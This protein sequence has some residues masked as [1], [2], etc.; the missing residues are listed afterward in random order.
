MPDFK[1]IE[2]KLQGTGGV[3]DSN[4]FDFL[5]ENYSEGGKELFERIINEKGGG[6]S[7]YSDD[8][9]NGI[10]YKQSEDSTQSRA[11][12]NPV[13]DDSRQ[14]RDELVLDF[15]SAQALTPSLRFES[16]V[17]GSGLTAAKDFLDTTALSAKSGGWIFGPSP[18]DITKGDLE[19]AL[20]QTPEPETDPT[21]GQEAD[22]SDIKPSEVLQCLLLKNIKPLS[23]YYKSAMHNRIYERKSNKLI[24][25]PYQGKIITL[26]SDPSPTFIN[27]LTLQKNINSNFTNVSKSDI[28]SSGTKKIYG[29]SLP[30]N[31]TTKMRLSFV[32][33]IE[34]DNSK[35]LVELPVLASQIS[36]E[37]TYQGDGSDNS[38]YFKERLDGTYSI[39]DSKEVLNKLDWGIDIKYEGTNPSTYRNDVTVSLTIKSNQIK[40]FTEAWKYYKGG[41]G[42]DNEYLSKEFNLFDLVLFPY[43]ES[44]SDG[45]GK[46]FKSQFSPNYNRVRLYVATIATGL[47]KEEIKQFYEK[48][49]TVLDLTPVDHEFTRESDGKVYSLKINYRGYIQSLLTSPELDSLTSVQIKKSRKSRDRALKQAAAQGC[50][51]KEMQKISSQL[52]LLAEND[53]KTITYDFVNK[54]NE[55]SKDEFE[56]YG[57]FGFFSIPINNLSSAI[58]TGGTINFKALSES[59][60]TGAGVNINTSFLEQTELD[61]TSLTTN[62][63]NNPNPT[64][65]QEKDLNL[66]QLNFFYLGDLL[67][68]VLSNTSVYDSESSALYA[69]TTNDFY[70]QNLRFIIGSFYDQASDSQINLAHIPISFDFFKEWYQ[71]T[72]LDK[73]L[74]IYPALSMMRDLVERVITNLLSEV[75]YTVDEKTSTL[76]RVSFFTGVGGQTESTDKVFNFWKTKYPELNK[77]PATNIDIPTL[78]ESTPEAP[79]IYPSFQ[80]TVSQHVNYCVLYTTGPQY[81]FNNATLSNT[82]HFYVD[83]SNFIGPANFSFKRTTETY[84]RESRYFRNSASGITQLAGVYDTTIDLA[85]PIYSIYP[86]TFYRVTLGAALKY[87][88]PNTNLDLFTELGINGYYSI[89]T[90]TIKL[91]GPLGAIESN[92]QIN[93]IWTDAE[94]P[95]YL[96]RQDKPDDT[97][98]LEEEVQS[99]IQEKC[100]DILNAVE[101]SVQSLG[102]FGIDLPDLVSIED[103]TADIEERR[104]EEQT[105]EEVEAQAR[106][107]QA[108]QNIAISDLSSQPQQI[109]LNAQGSVNLPA[110]TSRTIGDYTYLTNA[111]RT[112]QIIDSDKNVLS[113]YDPENGVTPNGDTE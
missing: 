98:S 47:L 86:S 12:L 105:N 99:A 34:T 79:L 83:N 33:Q 57:G 72:V 58:Q 28:I 112:V 18:E 94:N 54:F 93:G 25:Y 38:E 46:I 36:P 104:Q 59:I 71:E 95:F 84:M 92:V 96:I 67:D 77:G 70:K 40:T 78:D 106:E 61:Q 68:V 62:T 16:Y 108:Q 88:I 7:T 9:A 111:D 27:N 42:G 87:V 56:K 2:S 53:P 41:S 11:F 52:N 4:D 37:L 39:D 31:V 20:G 3:L 5:K 97:M 15:L 107:Q 103:I 73:E 17:S 110:G 24:S 81:G 45:Y 35:R 19:K 48:N 66:T 51:L 63:S 49:S 55:R 64:A 10:D 29:S 50:S 101:T 76:A 22:T 69:P 14:K 1:T 6:F 65:S 32:K 23:E 75:C 89:K 13:D 8:F 113:T 91:S 102:R 80:K 44:D 30:Q 90:V 74:F 82:P 100:L 109:L 85:V 43:Y 21:T 26:N 60:K